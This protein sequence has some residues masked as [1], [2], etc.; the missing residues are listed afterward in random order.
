MSGSHKLNT[1]IAQL[2]YYQRVGAR[3]LVVGTGAGQWGT[4]VAAACS[5][6][7]IKCTVYMVRSSYQAKPYRRTIMEMLGAEVIPSPSQET[8]CGRGSGGPEE[9]GQRVSVA[10]GEAL[11]AAERPNT[12]F[13]TGSGET[14]SLLHQTVIGIEARQQMRLAGE[15]PDVILG[16]LGGGSNFAGLVLP[17]LGAELRSEG[18]APR[19]YVSVEPAACPKLTR[20]TYAYDYTDASGSTPLQKM[21]TLGTHVRAASRCMRAVLRYHGTAK[22]ISAL[23]HRDLIEACAYPQRPVFASATAFARAEGIVPAPESAH[24]IHGGVVEAHRADAEG[25]NRVI[26]IGVSGHGMF[27][28]AAYGSYLD[29]S[30]VDA[31]ASEES[32]A[33][34]TGRSAGQCQCI[35]GVG[36]RASLGP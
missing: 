3:H 25:R 2:Y 29:G 32:I 33:A 9:P 34:R 21:Y 36:H 31:V 23:Y 16:S 17:F 8:A 7:D 20:G 4:A 11:E 19:G 6:L 1:A 14:Y 22:L 13:C 27:D 24:A 30:M 12:F 35:G 10:L 18:T 5:M 26:L 15:T 28:L